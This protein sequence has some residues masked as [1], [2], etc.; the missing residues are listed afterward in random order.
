MQ[1][2]G[3]VRIKNDYIFDAAGQIKRHADFQIFFLVT[4]ADNLDYRVWNFL[5]GFVGFGRRGAV[6]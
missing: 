5:D 6:D 4:F 2:F 3:G 1:N